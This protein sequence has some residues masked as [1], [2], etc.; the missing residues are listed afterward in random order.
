MPSRHFIS[1]RLLGGFRVASGEIGQSLP[2]PAAP[3][4]ASGFPGTDAVTL[5]VSES[6]GPSHGNPIRTGGT[7]PGPGRIRGAHG[8]S[9]TG[10]CH[11]KP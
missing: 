3:K 7:H 6:P 10:R 4:D 11:A 1:P 5:L 2:R 8:A 9:A